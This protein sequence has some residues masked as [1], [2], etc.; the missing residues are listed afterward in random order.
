[1]TPD[2]INASGQ[3]VLVNEA[4]E[5]NKRSGN[6]YTRTF[7]GSLALISTQRLIEMAGGATSVKVES[8]GDGNYKCT[9]YYP[10]DVTNGSN[11]EQPINV[12]ELETSMETVDVMLSDVMLANLIAMFGSLA[13]A[14]IAKAFV[15]CALNNYNRATEDPK[16]P[17]DIST[18]Q[19]N[20]EGLIT[21]TYSGGQ[22]AI[23]LN[24][25]RGI[26]YHG[27]TSCQQFKNTYSRRI[28]AATNYQVTAAYTGVGQIWTSAEVAAFEGLSS[29][30]A[31][32]SLN[33]NYLWLKCGPRVKMS[34]HQKTEV[35][36]EYVSCL[37]AWSGTFTAYSAASLLSF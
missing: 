28:T 32:F 12:H 15:Q 11:A 13:A 10:W 2:R 26:A 20:A 30:T 29:A 31:F 6:N 1:M 5:N 16:S 25:F 36:Y 4:L 35:A 18:A 22:A 3:I 7:T 21:S 14:T 37:Y 19:S 34:A 17:S 8:M 27:Q 33:S 23:M 24:L 9:S